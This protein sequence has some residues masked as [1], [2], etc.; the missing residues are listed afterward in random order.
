MGEPQS[1]EQVGEGGEGEGEGEG[2][3]G[4]LWGGETVVWSPEGGCAPLNR[5]TRPLVRL[6][7]RTAAINLVLIDVGRW[8]WFGLQHHLSNAV[9]IGCTLSEATRD[10]HLMDGIFGAQHA[11]LAWCSTLISLDVRPHSS[12]PQ[13][14]AL[15]R[16]YFRWRTRLPLITTY[17][18]VLHNDSFDLENY[19]D[20][21]VCLWW[22]ILLTKVSWLEIMQ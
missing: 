21:T 6:R 13:T 20:V 11:I 22:Q 19:G 9:L 5:T 7:D 3:G 16:T 10:D 2:R 12:S 4:D 18:N 14:D 1:Q 17:P 15:L 8:C